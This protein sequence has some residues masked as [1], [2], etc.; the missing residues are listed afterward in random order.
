MKE[1]EQIGLLIYKHVSEEISV[2]EKTILENW[3]AE[4]SDN[5]VFFE[6]AMNSEEILKEIIER[7]KIV[8]EEDKERAWSKMVSGGLVPTLATIIKP[9]WTWWRFSMAAAGLII[10]LLGSYLLLY[11]SKS[12]Q[13]DGALTEVKR[14]DISPG[15]AK[16]VLTLSDGRQI[17]VDSGSSVTLA[18]Q[19]GVKVQNQNGQLIYTGSNNSGQM[20]YNTLST[21]KGQV[22][23]TQLSDGSRV[24]LNS[25]SSI[26][27]PVA[28]LG[29]E[30]P[31]EIEGEA[32]FEVARNK[33]MPFKVFVNGIQVEVTGTSFSIF[34]YRDEQ[35]IKTTL[36]EGGVRINPTP[37]TSGSKKLV[38]L[39]PG[40]QAQIKTDKS[41]TVVDDFDM[42]E[43]MAW[44]NGM[45]VFN[46][47]D[48]KEIMK[49][50]ER[51][52]DVEVRY[53]DDVKGLTFTGQISRYSD[54]SQVL[55]M[56]EMMHKVHF[57]IDG[58]T[59]TVTQ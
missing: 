58:K 28:F 41:I 4:S 30:R 14:T 53:V 1:N 42:E 9:W 12:T 8:S 7:H 6:E 26:R 43:V 25:E 10:V 34:A 47:S 39:K 52:Y 11:K 17:A 23:S 57:K 29:K 5:K 19:D 49:Q 16:A 22:Y 15:Q 20:I 38:I 45:F 56:L 36:L 48:I 54:V 31:V 40:Q 32:Y 51:W 37:S 21:A 59:I 24:W 2:E 18:M 44:R 35:M 3:I 50:I 55:E 46:S 33:A 27:Y 13:G